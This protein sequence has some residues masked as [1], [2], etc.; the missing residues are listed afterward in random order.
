MPPGTQIIDSNGIK[1]VVCSGSVGFGGSSLI[2]S[3]TR[4]NSKRLFVIKECYP[5]P[6]KRFSFTRRN[7]IVCPNDETNNDAANYLRQIQRDMTREN[8]IAQRIANIS[9]RRIIAPTEDLNAVKIILNGESYDAVGSFFLVME[10]LTSNN[11][12]AKNSK[13][14]FVKDLLKECSLPPD[15]SSP[16]RNGGLPSPYTMLCVMEELLKP[17]RDIHNSG[18][19]HGDI[20]DGNF[21]LSGHNLSFGD[22]GIGTILDFGN[23]RELLEDNKTAP[24]TDKRIYGTEG[25]C[26]PEIIFDNDGT[27]QLTPA[28][29]IFSAGC[30]FLY[31][32]MG[33]DF[34]KNWGKELVS[35]FTMTLPVS[36]RELLKCGFRKSAA[37]AAEKILTK[38]LDFEPSFR[39]QN[40]G[41]MLADILELKKL[42]LPPRF[43]LAENLAQ[44]FFWVEGSRDAELAELQKSLHKSSP[45]YIWGLWGIGKTSL[46]VQF[47]LRQKECG[48]GAYMVKFR[49]TIKETVLQ[50]DFANYNFIFDGR[51]DA[52]EKE[53]LERLDILRTDYKDCLLIVDGFERENTL[54]SE[55]QQES[56]YNDL[57]KS[58]LHIIFTTRFRPNQYATELESLN[59]ESAFRLY[60]KITRGSDK[61]NF[62][63]STPAEEKIIRRLLRE[64]DYHTLTVELLA[65]LVNGSWKEL[66]PQRLLAEFKNHRLSVTDKSAVIYE[67]V[68]TLFNMC[69]FDET[70]RE[71]F[72]HVIFLPREG[73]DATIWMS[74]EEPVK[75]KQ[76]RLIESQGWIR[77]RRDNNR[78]HIH[79]LIRKL[80]KDVLKPTDADCDKFFSILWEHFE[81]QYPPDIELFKQVAELYERASNELQ[82]PRGDYSTHAGYSFVI[83]GNSPRALLNENKAIRI[84]EASGN[85]DIARNYNDKACVCLKLAAEEE[86]LTYLEK[87]RKLLE[88]RT[89]FQ[90][91]L[92]TVYSN[93]GLVYLELNH[94]E[95]AL[96]YARQ[97]V[98]L[99]RQNPPKNRSEFTCALTSL[100]KALANKKLYAEAADCFQE[101]ADILE[102]ILP[103]EHSDLAWA[104]LNLSDIYALA[105]K[106]DTALTFGLKALNIQEHC[107]PENHRDLMPTLSLLGEIYRS[108]GKLEKSKFYFNKFSQAVSK[109]QEKF[110]ADMLRKNLELLET[111]KILVARNLE[112]PAGISNVCRHIAD[113]YLTLKDFANARK[114]IELAISTMSDAEQSHIEDRTEELLSGQSVLN[115]LSAA[116]IYDADN[117][118]ETALDFAQKALVIA[119]TAPNDF[120]QQSL[121]CQ[122]LAVFCRKLNR[123]EEAL[124]YHEKHIELELKC[125]HP[126]RDGIQL[127][128]FCIGMILSDFGRTDEAIKLLEEVRADMTET[129][130]ASHH[131]VQDMDAII[132]KLKRRTEK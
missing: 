70:Y 15:K 116:D 90:P 1:Y 22:I 31:L 36:E 8:E 20:Q 60:Q 120:I 59:E 51:G 94:N 121:C 4:T 64:V 103:P 74:S 18:F 55:L 110:A 49:D 99:F 56:A 119:Q 28:S 85:D 129:L 95:E 37:V 117:E 25:F 14:W 72:C 58:G 108:M 68:R 73:F 9:G 16:L 52:R 66:T 11:S 21:F 39:Y 32:I 127:A 12:D 38:A 114:Y 118:T 69:K 113:N 71:I 102:E 105:E 44:D 80:L 27:L 89:S 84:R 65:S 5:A 107:L 122:K 3:V 86:A 87:A 29:D 23:A 63:P 54:M 42:T 48:V 75:K 92:A 128:K 34:K 40:A 123:N 30:F 6:S 26:S 124:H 2:Y 131:D 47:A 93:L 126:S 62:H 53:Y 98:E 112:T 81:D 43:Q 106:F 45:I 67:R 109:S 7:A 57:V 115:F 130:P 79:S 10:Q 132:S 83:V 19:L 76:L 24:I 50:M 35:S 101:A 33:N 82:D 91:E 104:Y 111:T 61:E 17:L 13:G 125:A 96:R 88:A 78:L 97:A 46:A 100:G 77:R 41:E